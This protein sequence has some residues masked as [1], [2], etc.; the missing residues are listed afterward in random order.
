MACEN[1]GLTPPKEISEFFGDN[2]PV[3]D[4]IL[5]DIDEI[6]SQY[7]YEDFKAPNWKIDLN[8][9]PKDIRYILVW[10]SY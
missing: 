9:M 7:S 10:L 3:S 5:V 1:A 6:T 8:K 4:G 2:E